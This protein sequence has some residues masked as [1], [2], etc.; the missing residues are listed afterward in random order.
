[1]A[2]SSP[3]LT[4][5]KSQLWLLRGSTEK[6]WN[7]LEKRI[8][9]HPFNHTVITVAVITVAVITVAEIAHKLLAIF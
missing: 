2:I 5:P 6:Q 4:S 1:M 8:K 3:S 9:D 7:N